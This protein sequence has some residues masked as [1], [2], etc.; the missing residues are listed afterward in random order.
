ML[1]EQEDVEKHVRSLGATSEIGAWTLKMTRRWET[2][3][4]MREYLRER[5]NKGQKQVSRLYQMM[6]WYPWEQV[7]QPRGRPLFSFFPKNNTT[8]IS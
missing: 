8:S 5:L 2:S 1:V 6:G 4:N 7:E 3:E